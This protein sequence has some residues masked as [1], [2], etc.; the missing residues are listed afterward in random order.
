MDCRKHFEHDTHHREKAARG[1][2]M[3]TATMM[4]VE[5]FVGYATR[6]M[7]LTADGWHMATH[8]GALGLTAAAYGYARSRARD[9][10]FTFG[11]G[12]VHALAGYTSA[13]LL[14]VVALS[15]IAQ[16]ALRLLHPVTIHFREALPVAVVGL[17]VNLASVK[18][19]D[20]DHEEHD[21]H[22][23]NHRAALMHVIADA[24]TSVLAIVAILAGQLV[25]WLWVD[26]AMG[27]VGGLVVLRWGI[28]LCRSSATHL[29]DAT[30]S[31][32]IAEVVRHTLETIDDVRVEDLH[33]W[34][35]APG[36]MSCIVSLSTSRPR[37]VDEY[38]NRVLAVV[39]GAHLTVEVHR[40]TSGHEETA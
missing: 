25:H 8:V 31:D 9:R 14:G 7:A 19:L 20:H 37:D 24:L 5:L 26:P 3:L 40:C 33:V 4:I 17:L 34:E 23:H 11:T 35:A 1:V 36:R 30:S 22:D 18:L 16:S 12:K 15:M 39:P 13:I 21:V 6:S 38:R 2:V 27:I 28:G 10:A 29:V 32:E